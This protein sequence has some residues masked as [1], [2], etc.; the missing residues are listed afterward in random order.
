MIFI[1]DAADMDNNNDYEIKFLNEIHLDQILYL[2]NIVTKNLSDPISYY[3]ESIEFFCKQIVIENGAIGL[4]K[5]DQLVGFNMASFPGLDEENLGIDV[6][7]KQE[8]LLLVAQF[9]PVAIHPDHRKRGLLNK[10]IERHI[11]SIKEIGY[12]HI[13]LTIAPSNYPA[14]RAAMAQ[15]F[16]IKRLKLKYNNLL[17]Y[18]L[19]LDFKSRFKHPQYSV[20]IPHT[21]IESQK[22]MINLGFYGYNVLKNDNGFDLVFGYDEIKA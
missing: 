3:V 9:G 10:I 7:I 17:R 18:I 6:G 13:C 22:F 8:E 1:A 19:H 16:I 15:G 11:N 21:D 2:Q 20:R 5:E 14:I 12:K 4:F